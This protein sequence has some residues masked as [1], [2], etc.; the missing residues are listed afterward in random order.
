[1]LERL[2]SSRGFLNGGGDIPSH[3][4]DIK[5][6]KIPRFKFAFDFEASKAIKGLGLE[7]SSET[8]VHKSCIEVDEVGSKAAAVI[9]CGSCGPPENKYD[10]V[11]D[12]PF[13]LPRQR[14]H[15]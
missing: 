15:K 13:F 5:E 7:L 4:A 12:H 14:R 10:F 1:M 6:V 3:W 2:A 8:I 11:A 9:R